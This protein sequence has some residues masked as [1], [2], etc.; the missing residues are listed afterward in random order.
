MSK[1]FIAAALLAL[2]TACSGPPATNDASMPDGGAGDAGT[3]GF[4]TVSSVHRGNCALHSSRRAVCW[5][6]INPDGFWIDDVDEAEAGFGPCFLRGTTAMCFR[7]ADL[8]MQPWPVPPADYRMVGAGNAQAC[9]LRTDGSAICWDAAG[10]I[11]D[12]DP[13]YTERFLKIRVDWALACGITESGSASCWNIG[14]PPE[15]LFPAP[16]P[17]DEYIDASNDGFSSCGINLAGEVRCA[18][19]ICRVD[20][21][22]GETT[23]NEPTFPAADG[24]R[25]TW[26]EAAGDPPP[27]PFTKISMMADARSAGLCALRPTGEVVCWGRAYEMY[28]R[29]TEPHGVLFRDIAT[30]SSHAC[31]V[32]LDDGEILCWGTAPPGQDFGQT[33]P[34]PPGP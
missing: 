20:G 24:G 27:G 26:S 18:P 17:G 13:I 11:Y 5:G 3:T 10:R 29:D 2:G 1:T 7:V 12:N 14:I 4:L 34:P 33:R 9:G 22:T 6:D 31:G 25:E 30:G 23:C 16:L 19:G 32:T 28:L 15:T 21:A 8:G